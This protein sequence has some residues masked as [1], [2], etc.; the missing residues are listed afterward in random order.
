MLNLW[1]TGRCVQ[2]L[3]F[4]SPLYMTE[5]EEEFHVL[6]TKLQ[7][8]H[9]LLTKRGKPRVC[10][11]KKIVPRPQK[12]KKINRKSKAFSNGE[13]I[14]EGLLDC[15]IWPTKEGTGERATLPTFCNEAG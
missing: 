15:V 10:F 5:H 14:K 2:I 7:I 1:Y 13:F 3:R 4:E 9:E 12:N 6:L 11:L 8:H